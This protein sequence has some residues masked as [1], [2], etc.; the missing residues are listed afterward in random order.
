MIEITE[1]ANDRIQISVSDKGPGIPTSFRDKIF[2]RFAQADGSATRMAGGSGLGL[3]ITKSI[4]ESLGGE[5][6]YD[7]VEGHGATFRLNFPTCT[8][9]TKQGDAD[10]KRPE[11][12]TIC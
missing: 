2:Q 11:Q 9:S 3:N 6:T 5:I 7:S 4:V 1:Q 10:G 12:D 8:S